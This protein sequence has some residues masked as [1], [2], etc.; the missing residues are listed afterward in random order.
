MLL[1]ISY[2]AFVWSAHFYDT[3]FKND[4][5]RIN[6][7]K[8]GYGFL[9]NRLNEVEKT[10]NIDILILGSSLA[11]RLIDTRIFNSK[12][13]KA[14]NLGSSSQTPL[15]TEF[16]LDKFFDQLD[17]KLII[18]D[19][20]PSLFSNSGFESYVDLVSNYGFDKSFIQQALTMKEIDAFHTLTL[21]LINE[22][23]QNENESQLIN[24]TK[25]EI[26]IKGGFVEN[27]NSDYKRVKPLTEI[28]LDLIAY[29]K[30]AFER[31][32]EKL[33]TRNLIL[34]MA[35]IRGEDYDLFIGI[36]EFKKYIINKTKVNHSISFYDFN[37]PIISEFSST[38]LFY[39]E[40]HLNKKGVKIYNRMLMD[41]ITKEFSDVLFLTKE[42]RVN[43]F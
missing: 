22:L 35:P 18:W 11:Y 1:A 3:K 31:V 17:P 12:G 41:I 9:A 20:S 34:V 23:L 38:S 21:V 14:F 37:D 30:S 27:L 19:V 33:K 8:N 24:Q 15:Q 5:K 6:E 26:Y 43:D 13:I 36:E 32:L 2:P 10:E 28:K 40:F 25:R 7:T 39:D 4:P 29:Q 42:N 16:L